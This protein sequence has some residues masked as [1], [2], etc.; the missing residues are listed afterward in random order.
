MAT[1]DKNLLKYGEK[2]LTYISY[3][4]NKHNTKDL[5]IKTSFKDLKYKKLAKNQENRLFYGALI[6]FS[7][8]QGGRGHVTQK[9]FF[10]KMPNRYLQAL[11]KFGGPLKS[12]F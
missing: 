10:Q 4:R 7:G 1:T 8:P 11:T 2:W 12:R 3:T 9:L 6:P 5:V